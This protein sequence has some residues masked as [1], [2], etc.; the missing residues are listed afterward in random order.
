MLRAVRSFLREN[1]VMAYLCM[2]AVRMLELHRVL[3]PTGS[4]YLHCDPTG[5]M[6][7]KFFSMQYLDQC[8]SEAKLY[9]GEQAHTIK[10]GRA[11]IHDVIFFYTRDE[12]YIRNHPRQ[13]I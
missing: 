8:H 6:I 9:G 11:P 13:P 12:N 1:D 10:Q 5:V 4:L 2:M 7:L 3:K